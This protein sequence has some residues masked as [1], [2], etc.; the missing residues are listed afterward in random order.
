MAVVF[1]GILTILPLFGVSITGF[2]AFG[3]AG[4]LA[5]GFAASDLLSNFFGSIMIFLDRPFNIGDKIS[6]PDR[7]IEGV[8][9]HIGWRLT[10]IRTLDKRALY[11]PNSLFLTISIENS[12]RRTS[13]RMSK[14]IALPHSDAN[15]VLPIL[16][17]IKAMLQADP[18]IDQNDAL[19]ANF[20]KIDQS[21]LKLM[22]LASISTTDRATFYKLQQKI[23]LKATKIIKAHGASV[24]LPTKTIQQ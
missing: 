14:V 23:L 12:A 1:I 10:R 22:I 3:G 6:S 7:D 9:E 16:A 19:L 20:I 4:A 18:H 15:K 17:E 11:V 2:L 21:S 5:I 24:A 13:R 8:V